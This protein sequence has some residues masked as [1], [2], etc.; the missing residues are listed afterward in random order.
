MVGDFY[1][2]VEEAHA[3]MGRKGRMYRLGDTVQVRLV[4]AIPSAGALRFELLSPGTPSHGALAKG[5]PKGW[6]GRRIRP[7]RA[8]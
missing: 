4:E 3:L 1:R 2:H 6:R 5:V 8:R 7:R